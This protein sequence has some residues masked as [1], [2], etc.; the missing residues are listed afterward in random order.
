MTKNTLIFLS[1]NKAIYFKYLN[2]NVYILHNIFI[3]NTY[4]MFHFS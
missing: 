3:I 1:T 4:K 2:N